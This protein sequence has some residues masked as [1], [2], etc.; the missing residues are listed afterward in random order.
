MSEQTLVNIQLLDFLFEFF[1]GCLK[2]CAI[3][4]EGQGIFHGCDSKAQ[5]ANIC[6]HSFNAL[7]TSAEC[8]IELLETSFTN[9]LTAFS[10]ESTREESESIFW[11]IASKRVSSWSNCFWS[12]LCFVSSA[13]EIHKCKEKIVESIR[14]LNSSLDT[15]FARAASRVSR[16]TRVVSAIRAFKSS[17]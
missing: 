17:I 5:F 4:L 15:I 8:E 16:R 9:D 7:E 10:A 2:L 1:D 6:R 13:C 11:S 12:A 3:G 14:T